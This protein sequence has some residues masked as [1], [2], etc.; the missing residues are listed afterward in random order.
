MR[1]L[2]YIS[3]FIT[4]T[5]VLVLT[6]CLS[7]SEPVAD[8]F[9]HTSIDIR[10]MVSITEVHWAGSIKNDGTDNNPDDDFIELMN[11]YEGYVDIGGWIVE[12]KGQ[13]YCLVHIPRGTVL[14]P[15]EFLTIGNNTDGAFPKLDIVEPNLRLGTDGF[16]I[17]LYDG[18]GHKSSDSLDFT[19]FPQ[20]PGGYNLPMLRKSAIRAT[21][22]FGALPGTVQSSWV[23]YNS[24]ISENIAPEY[25]ET[26]FA[27]P[28]SPKGS[29]AGS[30]GGDE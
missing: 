28:G 10:G 11:F 8:E 25:S 20:I 30:G 15:G 18:G 9:G 4:G 26:V 21:D 2:R 24:S 5:A 1:S 29:V 17:K 14:K 13:N 19:V 27:S 23:S 7:L 6:A 12:V 22:Y 3:I 16:S